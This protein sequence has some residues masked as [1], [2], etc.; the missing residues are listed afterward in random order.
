MRLAVI[1]ARGGSKRIPGKNIKRFCGKPII[2]WSI[3]AAL[4]ARCFDRVIVSTDSEEIVDIARATGA[5]VPF[6]RPTKLSDDHATTMDVLQHVVA[7]YDAAEPEIKTLTCIYAT[8][9]FVTASDLEAANAALGDDSV[10]YVFSAA[11]FPFPIQRGF[12]LSET[13]RPDLF[14]PE[15]VNTRSQDLTPAY[16]DA[17]QFYACRASAIREG[18]PFFGPRSVPILLDRKRVQD[19]DTPEDWDFAEALFRIQNG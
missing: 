15:H 18:A 11:E 4:R 14:Q 5:D 17:G 2:A 3:E 8:A 12:K 9:P 13:G 1:P 16:H 7:H 19:I 6:M 10:D